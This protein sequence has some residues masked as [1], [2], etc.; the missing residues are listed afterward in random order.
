MGYLNICDKFPRVKNNVTLDQRNPSYRKIQR[1]Y[2]KSASILPCRPP[3][4]GSQPSG[5]VCGMFHCYLHVIGKEQVI[6]TD[7]LITI[8]PQ[9]KERE[10]HKALSDFSK[11]ANIRNILEYLS[12]PNHRVRISRSRENGTIQSQSNQAIRPFLMKK[13]KRKYFAQAETRGK[14]ACMGWVSQRPLP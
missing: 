10:L 8:S 2:S 7:L 4:R 14:V 12:V 1:K 6:I 5:K 11:G 9:S 13:L 3:H